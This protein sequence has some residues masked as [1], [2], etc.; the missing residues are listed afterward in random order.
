ME[1]HS[2]LLDLMTTAKDKEEQS[3]STVIERADKRGRGVPPQ[4][5]DKTNQ[6]KHKAVKCNTNTMCL[7]LHGKQ[8]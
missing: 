3:L 5:N 2:L 7:I 1:L 8:R 4:S 6:T